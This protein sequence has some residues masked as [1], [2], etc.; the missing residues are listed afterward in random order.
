[1]IR[2]IDVMNMIVDRHHVHH[3][4]HAKITVQDICAVRAI[5]VVC[6]SDKE[7]QEALP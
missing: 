7:K 4:N 5:K 2:V 3:K 6:C 1:V